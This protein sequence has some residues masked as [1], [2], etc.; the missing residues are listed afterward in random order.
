MYRY[1]KFP[2]FHP[3]HFL[4][5]FF[6][7]FIFTLFG[8]KDA[9]GYI[10]CIITF[11]FLIKQISP[12]FERFIINGDL[13]NV[14]L[15]K[16]NY[17]IKIPEDAVFV[18]SYTDISD[19]SYSF[20]N[21]FTV[22]IVSDDVTHILEALHSKQ[23][24]FANN[25]SRHGVRLGKVIYNN[26]FLEKYFK[27]KW[28]YSF[29]YEKEFSDEFFKQQKKPVIVPRSI[30]DKIEIVANGFDVIFVEER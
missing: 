24:V 23:C 9:R 16:Q 6:F 7:I 20:K 25:P 3:V 12:F 2:F 26:L 11:F 28:I 8:F 17:D 1:G 4:E 5:I 22:N 10:A 14:S 19:F 21:R 13:I 18:L 30:A 15:F 29:V 27:N